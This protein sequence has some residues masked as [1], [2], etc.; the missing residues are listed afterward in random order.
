MP[1]I[2]LLDNEA[3]L[4]LKSDTTKKQIKY[5]LVPPKNH[6]RNAAERAIRTGIF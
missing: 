4:E 1:K 2:Y 3:S 6:C 5:Q